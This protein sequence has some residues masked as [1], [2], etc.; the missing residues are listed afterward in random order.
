MLSGRGGNAGAEENHVD[1]G[2]GC[3]IKAWEVGI[4]APRLMELQRSSEL[5]ATACWESVCLLVRI[6]LVDKL[7]LRESQTRTRGLVSAL[8]RLSG[9]FED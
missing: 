1:L 2:I 6:R 3:K 4:S 9:A 7:L 8:L 5:D